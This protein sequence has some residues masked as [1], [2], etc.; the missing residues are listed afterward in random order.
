MD[1]TA[2]HGQPCVNVRLRTVKGLAFELVDD[3]LREYSLTPVN[4]IQTTLIM[5]GILERL[6]YSSENYFSNTNISAGLISGLINTVN[7][8]RIAGLSVE[9]IDVDSF[10]IQHKGQNIKYILKEYLEIL[11]ANQLVDYSDVL[12]IAND[13]I[14]S[15]FSV[16]LDRFLLIVRDHD[17][18]KLERDLLDSVPRD[19]LIWLETDSVQTRM[20]EKITSDCDILVHFQ[21]PLNAPRSVNDNSV[22]IFNA[23]GPANEVREVFRRIL[24]PAGKSASQDVTQFDE[25]EILHTDYE[26]YVHVIYEVME[27]L[28]LS[29]DIGSES[30]P[31]TFTEGLP[32]R[33]SRPARAL[34][35]WIRWMSDDYPQATLIQMISDGLLDNDPNENT[36]GDKDLVS[37]LR[38]MKIVSGLQRSNEMLSK[39]LDEL[40]LLVQENKFSEEETCLSDSKHAVVIHE[41]DCLKGLIRIVKKLMSCSAKP[42]A[43]P[44]DQLRNAIRFLKTCCKSSGEID[45]YGLQ[46]LLQHLDQMEKAL[47][48]FA[49]LDDFDVITWIT[50]LTDKLRI[51][52]SGPRP[53]MIHVDNV[54]SGGHSGRHLTF[55][56]GLDD[57]KFPGS[58]IHDPLLMD[59][60]RE[61]ISSDLP[62]TRFES[63]KRMEKFG[64]LMARL[65]GNV[66]FSYSCSDGHSEKS[67]FP[68]SVLFSIFRIL[69][70]QRH[71][72]PTKM[73]AELGVPVCYVP[74][75]KDQSLTVNEWLLSSLCQ[76]SIDNKVQLIGQLRPNIIHGINAT[77]SR[78]SENFT[79][80]D[81]NIGFLE[82]RHD[83]THQDGPVMSSA[84]LETI[85]SCPRKYFF[86]Y[87]LRI[88]PLDDIDV[89]HSRWLDRVQLGVLLHEAFFEFMKDLAHEGRNTEAHRDKERL[90]DIIYEQLNGQATLTPPPNKSSMRRQIIWS[91]RSALVFLVEEEVASRGW[92][93]HLLEASIGMN[94]GKTLRE[95]EEFGPVV[96]RLDEKRFVKLSGKLDRVDKSIEDHANRFRIIDYKTGNPKKHLDLKNYECGKIVQHSVYLHMASN[97]IKS[98]QM[99]DS[100]SLEFVYFFPT[101]TAHGLRIMKSLSDMSQA[102]EVIQALCGIVSSGTFISTN[103]KNTCKYCEYRLICGDASITADCSNAKLNNFSNH[104]LA[105]AR[106]IL[107][108]VQPH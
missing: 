100:K 21:D 98:R 23:S 83:P 5:K 64:S 76:E 61:R 97:V 56:M 86:K 20:N 3:H 75:H 99:E 63:A 28:S 84:S 90:F 62:Q 39:R 29:F 53:G 35:T 78:L 37:I 69:S 68:S 57:E 77:Q 30:L 9:D 7:T 17:L 49:W 96:L 107:L 27:C 15:R 13:V 43:E 104:E 74:V 36:P 32:I 2:L 6:A 82:T 14:A 18:S 33:F 41:I 95:A 93:P 73:L 89:D 46:A 71:S 45:N 58:G 8:L 22:N 25:V 91:E 24:S 44:R 4:Q 106:K 42:E 87:I 40:T 51:M 101:P 31:I 59:S 79:D 12:S 108:N 85:G 65:R 103:D 72:D 16:E 34:R 60:E 88:R 102:T 105:D 26:T 52:G 11:Q 48:E 70:N 55:I 81:G 50:E 47:G 92:V 94:G 66:T 67:S 10:D 1:N 19:S 80:Y 38:K 54:Y